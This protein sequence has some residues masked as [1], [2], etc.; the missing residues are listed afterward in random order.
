MKFIVDAQL[1]KRLSEFL[2]EKGFDSIHTL[3]L[4]MKNFTNDITINQ[5]SI[6]ENRIVI[7]KDSDFYNSYFQKSEPYKLLFLKTGNINNDQL[8]NI[9]NSNITLLLDHLINHDV[10]ELT[11]KTIITIV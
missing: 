11:D 6:K 9:F 5:L 7:T 10:V 1:P 4:P 2:I 3:D 8:I